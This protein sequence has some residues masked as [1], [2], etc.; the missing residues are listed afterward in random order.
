MESCLDPMRIHGSLAQ[1]L[2]WLEFDHG[3]LAGRPDGMLGSPSASLAFFSALGTDRLYL[4]GRGSTSSCN[5]AVL[6]AQR[7]W[8]KVPYLAHEQ[9]IRL[10]GRV[11]ARP[12]RL[13]KRRAQIV[14]GQ[15]SAGC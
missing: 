6:K 7:V 11:G 15:S 3:R 13:D 1:R 2:G 10:C 9:D 14:E 5:T 4:R 8:G 12:V